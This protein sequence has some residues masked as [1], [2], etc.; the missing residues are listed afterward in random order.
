MFIEHLLQA[1]PAFKGFPLGF[2]Q[3]CSSVA[4]LPQEH[5]TPGVTP[6][7]PL[8][9]WEVGAGRPWAGSGS[10]TH[11]LCAPFLQGI[12]TGCAGSKV[13]CGSCCPQPGWPPGPTGASGWRV[14]CSTWRR[15][16]CRSRCRRGLWCCSSGPPRWVP[17]GAGVR[18]AHTGGCVLT[19]TLRLVPEGPYAR[20]WVGVCTCVCGCTCGSVW[21]CECGCVHTPSCLPSSLTDSLVNRIIHSL[22][23]YIF[24][25][26]KKN[27]QKSCMSS[28]MNSYIL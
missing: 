22:C 14:T 4:S 1:R 9:L 10:V 3:G 23:I 28:F 19:D 20:A 11:I 12:R 25:F 8:A 21:H 7:G 13:A 24:L 26:G 2:S 15:W 27:L 16:A 17:A 18:C 5:P 6:R